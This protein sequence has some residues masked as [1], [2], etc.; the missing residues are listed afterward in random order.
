MP[1]LDAGPTTVADV[2]S[3]TA[4][5]PHTR[6]IGQAELDYP[7]P[8]CFGVGWGG[9]GGS[10]FGVERGGLEFWG[11]EGGSF[12]FFFFFL[13]GG[14]GARSSCYGFGGGGGGELVFFYRPVR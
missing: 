4:L 8:S 11:G 9:G 1:P 3:C 2:L 7:N 6:I 12:F 10:C 14:G 5:F 13:G